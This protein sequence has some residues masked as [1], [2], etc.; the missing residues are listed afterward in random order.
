[1]VEREELLGSSLLQSESASMFRSSCL[2][3]DGL[4]GWVLCRDARLRTVATSEVKGVS[5]KA[6]D[7]VARARS[8]E[9]KGEEAARACGKRSRVLECTGGE[10]RTTANRADKGEA[11]ADA[12]GCFKH[13]ERDFA[14]VGRRGGCCCSVPKL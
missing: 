1:M 13:G 3:V 12:T 9:A 7:S 2:R 11:E 14:C 4:S 6:K 8:E 5:S 10:V